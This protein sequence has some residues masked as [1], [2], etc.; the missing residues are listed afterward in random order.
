MS[1]KMRALMLAGACAAALSGMAGEA[2][3]HTGMLTPIPSY[4]DPKGGSTS[5]L[6]INN[7]GYMTG[8]VGYLDGSASGFTRDPGGTYTL[9]SLGFA[10]QG[11]AISESNTVSGYVTDASQNQL[12]DNEFTRTSGGAV[13]LLQNPTDL[14]FLRGIA[15]GMN[16][17]GAIVGDYFTAGTHRHGYIL[18]GATFTDL[19]VPGATSTRARAITDAG[20]VAGWAVIGGVSEGFIWDGTTFTFVNDP[21]A[22]GNTYIED[23]NNFGI[24]SGAWTDGAG[25]THAYE[26]DT[27]TGKFTEINVPGATNAE[28][29]GLDDLGRAVIT[30]DL[31][32]G[33]NNFLYTPVPE[34]AGW[35]MLLLGVF[36]AGAMLRRRRAALAA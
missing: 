34:P 19:V 6:G 22:V 3:A 14:S 17:S 32:T 16:S 31:A 11:R 36:G 18:D 29:F 26:Y 8:S 27:H 33:P 13:T 28:A 35:A 21:N 4:A 25:N 7:A 15:Q 24:A 5:V 10:T 1:K 12:T 20:L 9:F 23:L 30:T 2:F